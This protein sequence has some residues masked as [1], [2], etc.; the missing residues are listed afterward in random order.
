MKIHPE[1]Y[2]II[3]VAFLLLATVNALLRW[4][5]PHWLHCTIAGASIVFFCMIV[6]F[7][8]NPNRPLTPDVN[9]VF[10]PAD[11]EVVAIE[12][13]EEPEYFKDKRIQ[14]S[15]F[16]SPLNVHV[17]RYP[18][19]GIVTYVKYHPGKY[20][21]AW[22]P[23]SSL[24]NERSTVAVRTES[25][26][27]VLFRQIAGA[28]ARRIVTYPKAGDTAL[29]G[30]DF[31]FIKFGSRVDVFLPLDAHIRVKIGDK[32]RGNETVLADFKSD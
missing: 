11:G 27:E 10:A 22:H 17:N 3:L 23:K 30:A 16:M 7:F 24:L 28:V 19:S 5:S 8:R 26:Q 20:L 2:V 1:G 12:E 13:V 21:V 25:G 29:Q 6:W 14:V 31:G 18:V 32:A 15:I 4:L 9:K